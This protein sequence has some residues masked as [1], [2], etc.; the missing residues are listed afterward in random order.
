MANLA[1]FDIGPLTWVK[2]EIDQALTRSLAALR[3]F[4]ANPSDTAQLR[5]SQTHFHQAHGALQIVG[6][7]GVAKVS[8]E[9]E[10]LLGDLGREMRQSALAAAERG[11]SSISTY[12]EQLLAGEP[13]QPL[14]LFANYRELLIERREPEPDPVDLYYPDLTGRAP[15]RA[16][17]APPAIGRRAAPGIAR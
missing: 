3:A 9:I 6:L 15:R 12:L 10:S 16:E 14:K 11:F 7:D 8:E 13:N 17:D 4:A 1:E 2:G 5:Y